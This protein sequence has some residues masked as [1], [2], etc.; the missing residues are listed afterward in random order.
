MLHVAKFRYGATVPENVHIVYPAQETV[1]HLAK[2]GWLPS[3]DVAAVTKP[4]REI[5]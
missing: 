1:K 5:R 3:S 4:R 2:F